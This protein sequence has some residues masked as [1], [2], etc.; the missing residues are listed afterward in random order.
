MVDVANEKSKLINS[1]CFTILANVSNRRKYMKWLKISFKQ[2]WVQTNKC[3][4][5][6]LRKNIDSFDKFG[7]T[8]RD[9]PSIAT[10]EW[11]VNANS[12]TFE[13]RHMKTF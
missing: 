11:C 5:S 7:S 2:K 13:R 4:E 10:I 12:S 9:N 8:F 3:Y 1:K 6:A